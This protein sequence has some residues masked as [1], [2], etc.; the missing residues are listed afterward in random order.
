[1]N[2]ERNRCVEKK[3]H[4]IYIKQQTRRRKKNIYSYEIV[5]LILL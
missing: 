2:D 3:T 1:M 5:T 4:K